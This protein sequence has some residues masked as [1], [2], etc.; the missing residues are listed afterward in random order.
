MQIYTKN[1]VQETLN[2]R[3]EAQA[4]KVRT[5]KQGY[6]WIVTVSQRVTN[7]V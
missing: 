1:S 6:L 4:E 5:T 7:V 3:A 2:Q